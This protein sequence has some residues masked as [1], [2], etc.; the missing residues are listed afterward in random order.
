MLLSTP[1][2]LLDSGHLCEIVTMRRLA[3]LCSSWIV[4]LKQVFKRM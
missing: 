3:G 1:R 2:L 4:A